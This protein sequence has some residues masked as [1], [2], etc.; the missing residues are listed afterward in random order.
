MME[1]KVIIPKVLP[2]DFDV[3]PYI[4]KTGSIPGND[5]QCSIQ[6]SASLDI[7]MLNSKVDGKYQ[8]VGVSTETLAVTQ[9]FT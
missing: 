2:K 8:T 5:I 7:I 4:E 3:T 1:A 6:Y 9:R